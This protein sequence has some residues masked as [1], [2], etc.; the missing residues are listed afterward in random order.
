[1]DALDTVDI[2]GDFRGQEGAPLF[3]SSPDHNAQAE[4]GH[5]CGVVSELLACSAHG[6]GSVSDP[7]KQHA[8]PEGCGEQNASVVSS[9][10]VDGSLACSSSPQEISCDS[11]NGRLLQPE[12]YE[13]LDISDF[14]EDVDD[15]R[16]D[17]TSLSFH[18]A[19]VIPGAVDTD[20][21]SLIQ[22]CADLSGEDSTA[23]SQKQGV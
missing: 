7:R 23:T 20:K 1:M 5:G 8:S 11:E 6:D 15:Y 18:K 2:G 16:S 17:T 10:T 14:E 9:G 19:G 4:D 22:D 12:S 13:L 21:P 3:S